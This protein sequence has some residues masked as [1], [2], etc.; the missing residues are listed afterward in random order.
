[1]SVSLCNP[2]ILQ[3]TQRRIGLRQSSPWSQDWLSAWFSVSF[4]ANLWRSWVQPVRFWSLRPLC[5]TFARPWVGSTYRSGSGQVS[6][7]DSS[8]SSLW[9]RTLRP[10]SVISQGM[11]NKTNK[12]GSPYPHYSFR[13]VLSKKNLADFSN[14]LPI[15]GQIFFAQNLD[16][17]NHYQANSRWSQLSPRKV[18]ILNKKM[19]K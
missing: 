10:L 11:Q 3:V 13:P 4:P 17:N 1:M 5:M 19:E 7:V 12:F 18:I 14:V 2:V 15:F 9:P 8:W 6:G 16:S